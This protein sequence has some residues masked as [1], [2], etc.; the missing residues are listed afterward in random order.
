MAQFQPHPSPI[1]NVKRMKTVSDRREDALLV[2]KVL[3]WIILVSLF[4]SI[5]PISIGFIFTMTNI[6]DFEI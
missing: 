5:V 1:R 2:K 4:L 3:K 6:L